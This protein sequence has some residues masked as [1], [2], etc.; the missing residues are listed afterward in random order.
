MVQLAAAAE[1]VD[2]Q[3]PK[4]RG[5]PWTKGVSGNPSGSRVNKR[6]VV[7]AEQ[8]AADFGGTSS[9]GAIDRAMI[10]QAAKLLIRTERVKDADTALRM[11]GEARRLLSSLR[12]RAPASVAPTESFAE[13]AARAQAE[14]AARRARELAEDEASDTAADVETRTSDVLPVTGAASGDEG[15]DA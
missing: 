4:V 2:G 3:R 5:R 15:R 13:I 14:A 9:L 12:R 1:Q 6:A 8:M 7:L 11:S 10:E